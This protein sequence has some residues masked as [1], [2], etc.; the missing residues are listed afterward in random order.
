[1]RQ[2]TPNNP[3]VDVE[4]QAPSQTENPQE[5]EIALDPPDVP[6]M[7]PSPEGRAAENVAK[8]ASQRELWTIV[9]VADAGALKKNASELQR[10][11]AKLGLSFSKFDGGREYRIANVSQE[12]WRSLAEKLDAI[13]ARES[14][15]ALKAWSEN[16]STKRRNLRVSFRLQEAN[17]PDA[18]ASNDE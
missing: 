11:C 8:R 1:M 15:D 5:F 9:E 3:I 7:T 4:P 18:A 17:T 13:G 2:E 6:V 12:E 16:A 14:S 10:L